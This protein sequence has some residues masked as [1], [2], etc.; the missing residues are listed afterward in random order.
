[1]RFKTFVINLERCPEKRRKMEQRLKG[2][3]YEIFKAYD[4][5]E[6][7][8]EIMNK[9]D[10]GILKEWTDPY[11]GRNITWG[12]VGCGF[13]HYGVMEKCVREN[14]EVAVILE[15]DVLIPDNFSQHINI[16]HYCQF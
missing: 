9:M 15:D 8:D 1:M 4:G 14:I 13:S 10:A 6:L 12:E 16:F 5:R 7:N 11:S 2:E 3:E